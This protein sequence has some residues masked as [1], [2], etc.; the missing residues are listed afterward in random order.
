[1]TKLEK[2]IAK[3]SRLQVAACRAQKVYYLLSTLLKKNSKELAQANRAADKA[4]AAA[5]RAWFEVCAVMTAQG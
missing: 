5:D 3:A 1:M 4:F 2:A